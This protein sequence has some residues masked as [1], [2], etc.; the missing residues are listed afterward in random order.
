MNRLTLTVLILSIALNFALI[1]FLVGRE[2]SKPPFFDPTRAFIGWSE[3]LQPDR[4]LA[5]RA[6]M[7]THAPQYRKHLLRLRQ[8]N[9]DLM[10]SLEA[11][12]LEPSA[13]RDALGQMR[14]AHLE[15]QTQSHNAFVTFV[16]ALTLEER[17]QLAADISA[18]RPGPPAH[19]MGRAGLPRGTPP[20]APQEQ[21]IR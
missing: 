15:A 7:R 11:D 6:T 16:D 18:R 10:R 3:K 20:H 17:R 13:L 1:G 2:Q 4:K 8:H 9:R 14:A 5:L 19:R 12:T 21:I